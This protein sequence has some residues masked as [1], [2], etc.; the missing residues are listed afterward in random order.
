[1]RCLV[2]GATGF[3]GGHLGAALGSAGHEVV[4]LS[5]PGH[6]D[7]RPMP[8]P[9]FR[10]DLT[11]PAELDAVLAESRPEWI[12]HLAGFA[13]PGGSFRDAP[14]AWAGNLTATQNLYDAIATTGLKPRVLF[15][16]SGLIYGDGLSGSG[17][18]AETAELRPASPY[19]ASKAAADLL[20]YQ[21]TRSAGLDI[22]RVRLF[23]QIGPGQSATYAAANFARQIA[24]VQLGRSN[25]TIETGDLSASR[26][27]TDVRDTVRAFVRLLEV[28][29]SGEAY[30]AGS[31]RTIRL[32]DLLDRLIGMTG[33]QV[34]VTERIDPDR[35]GDTATSWADM[36][37]LRAAT[38]WAPAYA[39]DQTLG[40]ML[41]DWRERLE[42]SGGT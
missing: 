20:S 38:G 5:R 1:M 17:P 4:G 41:R 40:D 25:P 12:F 42:K 9:I 15:V 33:L 10:A 31:G 29:R 8:F 14:G 2:T 30:N 22:V 34:K 32:R 7:D 19:A 13:S 26:D 28:G 18:F 11:I 3:V 27:F 16:S 36:S 24:A 6:S 23:N 37:K 39:L 21:V 35:A